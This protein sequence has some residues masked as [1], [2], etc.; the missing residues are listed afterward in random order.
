M[1]NK[2]ETSNIVFGG[3]ELYSGV[4]RKN[5]LAFYFSA[6]ATICLLSFINVV[7]PYLLT[8]M[9]Q[10]PLAEQGS[11][12]GTVLFWY[13][14][15]IIFTIGLAGSLSD[16]VGRRLIFTGSFLVIG[17]GYVLMAQSNAVWQLVLFRMFFAVG[18]AGA[19]S[20]LSVVIADYVVGRDRGKANG[21]QGVMNGLG[22]MTAVFLLLRLPNWFSQ[23]GLDP[24]AAGQATYYVAGGLALLSG[25]VLW[26]GLKKR[27]IRQR[28]QPERFMELLREGVKAGRDP[29]VLL[30]YGAG[31]VS[32][33]DLVIVGTFLA[34]WINKYG[35]TNGMDTAVALAR[36][37]II[38][39]IS[40]AAAFVAAPLFG[41][42]AD[43]MNRATAVALT[44][45]ISG[46][47]YTSLFFVDDPFGTAMIAAVIVAGAGNIGTVISTQV[48]IQQQAPSHIRGSVIGF[49]GLC[50]AIGILAASKLGGWLFDYWDESGPFVLFG[51]LSFILATW[52][53]L[54]RNRIQPAPEEAS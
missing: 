19:T 48:L 13:E 23:N 52:A 45:V 27:G 54:I 46:I 3:V 18:A 26:L 25:I 51:L 5:M 33:G 40:Q 24:I 31:F 20:M 4:T 43:K 42:L 1:D 53:F 44:N 30:G 2:T 34:L 22:A 35:V 29:G 6:F 17:A 15:V 41:F 9:L 39:G 21:F 12:T 50:G 38:V 32:R 16:K 8:E 7:Q 28:N 36:A 47:G 49:F 37:S 11:V 14:I 10:V